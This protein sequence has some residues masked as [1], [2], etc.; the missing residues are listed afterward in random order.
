VQRSGDARANCLI[1][2]PPGQMIV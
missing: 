2:C 1:I